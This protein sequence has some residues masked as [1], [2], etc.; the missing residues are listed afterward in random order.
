MAG[1]PR[2]QGGTG[3]R[4]PRTVAAAGRSR[5]LRAPAKGPFKGGGSTMT[6]Y[7]KAVRHKLIKR[8]FLIHGTWHVSLSVFLFIIK[9]VAF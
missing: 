4:A 6:P 3:H 8:P 7:K 5:T 9:R 2:W 1:P